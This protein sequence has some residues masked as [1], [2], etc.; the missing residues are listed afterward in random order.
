MTLTRGFRLGPYEILGALGVGGMA[1]FTGRAIHARSG[2]LPTRISPGHLSDD[3]M[4]RQRFEYE[5]K[6]V[7][8]LNHLHICTLHDIGC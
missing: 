2:R 4:R 1:R 6:V 7:S 5:A 8:S 3:A